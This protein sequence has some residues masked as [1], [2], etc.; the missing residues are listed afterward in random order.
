MQGLKINF[1][2]NFNESSLSLRLAYQG[3][4][5][6]FREWNINLGHYRIFIQ[7]V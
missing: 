5:V 2:S 6:E 3:K 4:I 7:E 1:L